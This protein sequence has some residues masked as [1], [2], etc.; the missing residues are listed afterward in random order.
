[1]FNGL[2]S[3]YHVSGTCKADAV[4]EM[5][6]LLVIGVKVLNVCNLSVITRPLD[7]HPML[8]AMAIGHLVGS[9]TGIIA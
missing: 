6:S 8:T 9:S 7:T 3:A 5:K 1:M 4:V 2:A